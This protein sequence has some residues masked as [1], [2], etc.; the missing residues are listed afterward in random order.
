M[1]RG[2]RKTEQSGPPKRTEKEEGRSP[3]LAC[4]SYPPPAHSPRAS[5]VGFRAEEAAAQARLY[6]N[7]GKGRGLVKGSQHLRPPHCPPRAHLLPLQ[8]TDSPKL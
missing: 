8:G 1:R 6:R 3:D 5:R 4:L 2:M 7:K